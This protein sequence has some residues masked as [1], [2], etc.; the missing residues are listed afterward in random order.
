MPVVSPIRQMELTTEGSYV[1]HP[2]KNAIPTDYANN[3]EI[4]DGNI[5]DQAVAFWVVSRDGKMK[6]TL[7]AEALIIARWQPI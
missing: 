5:L 1:T 2:E 3:M 4:D 7:N 6:P